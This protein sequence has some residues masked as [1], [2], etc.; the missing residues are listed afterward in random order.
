M[1]C[2]LGGVLLEESLQ[3]GFWL[4]DDVETVAR[5]FVEDL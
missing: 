5:E 4:A 3:D 2:G 1:N